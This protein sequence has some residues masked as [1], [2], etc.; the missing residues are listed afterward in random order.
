LK[1]KTILQVPSKRASLQRDEN[2]RHVVEEVFLTK[3]NKC[4]NSRECVQT[5]LQQ[6]QRSS[7]NVTYRIFVLRFHF[8]AVVVAAVVVAPADAVVR[9]TKKYEVSFFLI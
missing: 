7:L 6:Q 3:W 9:M 1:I 5:I 2:R 8:R 4:V